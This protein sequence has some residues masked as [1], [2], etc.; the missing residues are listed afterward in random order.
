MKRLAF[1]A[2][3]AFL[4]STSAYADF[5]AD[6]TFIVTTV[7]K[8]TQPADTGTMP[9][10]AAAE[11]IVEAFRKYLADGCRGAGGQPEFKPDFAMAVDVNADGRAD[12][13][14]TANRMYCEGAAS[15]WS[16][17]SGSTARWALSK[18]DGSYAIADQLHHRVEI[19]ETLKNGYQLIVHLHGANCG[20]GGADQCRNVVNVDGN[21]EIR[22]IAW[23]D[24]KDRRVPD[25][26]PAAAGAPSRPVVTAAEATAAGLST[27]MH[28][29]STMLLD[30]RNGRITYEEPKT[31]IAGTVRKGAVLFEGR[32]EGKRISGTAY[33][34]KKGCTPAPYPVDGRMEKDPTGFGERIVLSGPAP[35]RDRNSCAIIGTTSAHSRLV[36][37]EY[38]DI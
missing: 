19:Q 21:G 24:G 31:S 3:A 36:F 6:P 4:H 11:P 2:I 7:A 29:G 22:S 5:Q 1:A 9:V 26:P 28:N 10:P 15:Y 16:G 12:V 18:A 37:E 30:E 8:G 23:P 35:R 14:M 17:S 33:V 32:F 13:F 27:W 25:G 20:K 34:F 38:G